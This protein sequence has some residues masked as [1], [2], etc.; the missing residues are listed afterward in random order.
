EIIDAPHLL[1][2]ELKKNSIMQKID[3]YYDS[4]LVYGPPDFLLFVGICRITQAVSQ[5]VESQ[6]D[7]NNR[8]DRIEQPW[9]EGDDADAF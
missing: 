6:N 9:I 7:K 8:N 1:E 5:K 3:Q 2:A 4:V